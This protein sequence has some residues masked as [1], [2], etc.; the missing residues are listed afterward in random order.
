MAGDK[1]AA[2][3]QLKALL[4]QPAQ[5]SRGSLAIDRTLRSLRGDPEFEAL[6]G[7]R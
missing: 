3:A 1:A 6:I 2:V 5:Q 4:D 7:G